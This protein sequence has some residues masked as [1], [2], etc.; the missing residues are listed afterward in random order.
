[1]RGAQM[2]EINND[3]YRRR[4]HSLVLALRITPKRPMN[5]PLSSTNC[6]RM[7][8]VLK[9][10]RNNAASLDAYNAYEAVIQLLHDSRMAQDIKKSQ[11]HEKTLQSRINKPAAR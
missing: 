8:D 9:A 10:M 4:I 1:M 7:E 2:P 3:A 5:Y 11:N 6:D